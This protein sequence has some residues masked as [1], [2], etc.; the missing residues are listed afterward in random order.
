MS[1]LGLLLVL[2][3]PV[4]GKDDAFNDWYDNTHVPEVLQ[5]PGVVA[6]QRYTLAPATDPEL[7]AATM[8]THRYLAVYEIDRDASGVLEEVLRRLNT[9]TIT[10]TDTI[11]AGAFSTWL[12]I[13][14]RHANAA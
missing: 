11:E 3:N 5:V 7:A 8:A 6:A 1:E 13:G 14:E 12:P 9:G 10:F 4:S 2:S